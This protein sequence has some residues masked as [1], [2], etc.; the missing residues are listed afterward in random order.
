MEKQL[1][2]FKRGVLLAEGRGGEERRGLLLL[3]LLLL[4][5]R[6]MNEEHLSWRAG[7]LLEAEMCVEE[8]FIDTFI[9][10][11]VVENNQEQGWCRCLMKPFEDTADSYNTWEWTR[12]Y[13]A[14]GDSGGAAPQWKAGDAVHVQ[15]IL[16]GIEFT[17]W[18]KAVV[19]EVVEVV[20]CNKT[21]AAAQYVVSCRAWD[22]D[23]VVE[24]NLVVEAS[25]IRAPWESRTEDSVLVLEKKAKVGGDGGGGGGGGGG[26]DG[27]L[28][29]LAG[30]DDC[31]EPERK[32]RG[33]RRPKACQKCG[34]NRI[35][36]SSAGCGYF[37]W[38]CAYYPR[39][40]PEEMTYP[41]TNVPIKLYRFCQT[42]MDHNTYAR[43]M[44]RT[45]DPMLIGDFFL[46]SQVEE[47]EVLVKLFSS[48]HCKFDVLPTSPDGW[49]IFGSVAKGTET[50]LQ[51]L[52][53]LFKDY[54]M[55][56]VDDLADIIV[57][58][59]DMVLELIRGLDTDDSDSVQEL[60]S[61]FGGDVLVPLLARYLN[62]QRPGSFQILDWRISSGELMRG[63]Y[64]Y[65]DDG[66][67]RHTVNLLLINE[68]VPHY[69]L[70]VP[71]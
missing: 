59:R 2:I 12:L 65:P 31:V 49:C 13:G 42:H 69:D 63:H 51:Q 67:Y 25:K 50:T 55:N 8:A 9:P 48:E 54:V 62:H 28:F 22:G 6:M 43:Y 44:Q 46:H 40:F 10:V 21:D 36:C 58:E 19:V 41:G 56:N 14:R 16:P 57:E 7:T 45:D 18:K 47:A 32:R 3:L 11:V 35:R 68:V 23:E 60:W 38:K 27:D 37:C 64:A 5:A 29:D 4:I 34:S 17:V 30:G 61:G 24:E 39:D 20:V 70:L 52:I 66:D 33:G 1:R 53:P 71:K 26:G 15:V